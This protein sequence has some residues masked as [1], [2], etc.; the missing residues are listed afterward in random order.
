MA[1]KT[2]ELLT[3]VNDIEN[4]LIETRRYLHENPELSGK[5]FET[6]K[7]L[8]NEVQK[9]GLD[10]VEV[11]GTG[12]YA[13]LDTGR[14]G[15]TIALR[16]DIDALP[17]LENERNLAIDRVCRSKSEGVFHA[18]GHDG[19]MAI[20]LGAAKILSDLKDELTGR[21]IFIFEEGE[22]TGS[23]IDSM[24]EAL[25]LEKID[26]IYGNHLASFLDS[27]KVSVDSGPVMAGAAL[28]DFT[29]R[30]KGGHGSRPDLS[31]NPIFAASNILNGLTSAWANRI[32]VT[33]TVTLGLG[34][35]NGGTIANVIPDE[36]RITGTLRYFDTEEGKKAVDQVKKVGKLTAQA[37]ECEFIENTISLV[38]YPLINDD[39]L[40]EIA[41]SSI[42]EVMPENLVSDVTWFASESFAKY[43]SIADILFAFIGTRNEELGSGAEHHNEYFDLDEASLGVGVTTMVKFTIDYLTK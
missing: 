18:C 17:V 11:K 4:Y 6:S 31:I 22:E 35:I 37:H 2:K 26:A 32:D 39:R 24:I 42:N 13:V 25:K 43:R 36:V 38:T 14:K 10:I 7:F 5:E 34:T 3:K 21:I 27:K 29:I 8:K 28:V 40:S 41:K 9:L 19:H 23:G 12:F 20:S 30:G 16:T 33:K 1:I 15:K